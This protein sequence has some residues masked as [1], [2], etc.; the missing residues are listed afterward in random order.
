MAATEPEMIPPIGVTPAIRTPPERATGSSSE[1]KLTAT[2]A[3]ASGLTSP[4]SLVS[5]VARTALISA[6]PRTVI[7]GRSD[8]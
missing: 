6:R 3:R 8:G 4:I 7:G 2:Y 5:T 1:S